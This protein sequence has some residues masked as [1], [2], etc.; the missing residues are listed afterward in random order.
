VSTLNDLL[1]AV[2]LNPDEDVPRLAFADALD[3]LPV[4]SSKCTESGCDKGWRTVRTRIAE[5]DADD[6]C[7]SSSGCYKCKG[8]GFIADD[9]NHLRAQFIRGQMQTITSMSVY[10]GRFLRDI[11]VLLP[12]EPWNVEQVTFHRGF[13]RDIRLTSEEFFKIADKLIW[14]PKQ[15]MACPE[16]GGHGRH[17]D[18][19][20]AECKNCGGKI[21]TGTCGTGKVLRP[22]PDTAH[23]IKKVTF[24]TIPLSS[25]RSDYAPLP[26]RWFDTKYPGIEFDVDTE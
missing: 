16:C 15:T 12:F 19:S 6:Y 4:T 10:S 13:I 1:K 25:A 7:L 11:A 8:T 24:T 17:A 9:R 2:I 22:C 21:G 5:M 14:H 18:C 3:E 26:M 20:E 23:P